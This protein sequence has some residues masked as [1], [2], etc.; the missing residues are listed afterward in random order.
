M[1]SVQN[2]LRQL[3][4]SKSILLIIITAFTV[5]SCTVFES[6][7]GSKSGPKPPTPIVKKDDSKPTEEEP[8]QPEVVK[9]DKQEPKRQENDTEPK[10]QNV[11]SQKDSIH[12]AIILP[13]DLENISAT[14]S[15]TG[16]SKNS[17]YLYQGM[18]QV[19]DGMNFTDKE[20]FIHVLDN[21]KDMAKTLAITNQNPFPK[22]DLVIG[23]AYTSNVKAIAG[24]A[25]RNEIPFI[26][27]LSS[28]PSLTVGNDYLISANATKETRYKL[29][30]DFIQ[31]KFIHPNVSVIA[32]PNQKEQQA[33]DLFVKVASEMGDSLQTKLSEG[34]EMFAVAQETLETGR[35]NVII[36]P[37]AKTPQGALYLSR[38]L[39][40][41]HELTD[42][43]KIR[44]IALEE[45]NDSKK[46][47]PIKYPNIQFYTLDRYF[48]PSTDYRKMNTYQQVKSYNNGI[49]PHIYTLHG[50]DLM[51][52]LNELIKQ[53]GKDFVAHLQDTR[54]E[55]VQTNFEFRP[56]KSRGVSYFIENKHIHILKYQNGNYVPVND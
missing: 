29:L 33:K 25:S 30:L 38:M 20:V 51:S 9:D 31:R 13:F 5:Q 2:L 45:W 46:I 35:E 26:S 19:I 53:Y 3:N 43:Y 8:K 54:F 44:V 42:E 22:I 4:G 18:K 37:V 27:P 14:N 24:F 7:F 49:E 16:A 10:N 52:Y 55:G 1:T 21:R 41:L 48:V 32:Q 47:A 12:L 36:L 15:Y 39:E 28:S 6:I 11:H 23:P 56:F 40:F 17:F 50:F 34:L